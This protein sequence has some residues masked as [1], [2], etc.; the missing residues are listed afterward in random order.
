MSGKPCSQI[1]KLK[2]AQGECVPFKGI[3]GNG[4][5]GRNKQASNSQDPFVSSALSLQEL[6]SLHGSLASEAVSQDG[7]ALTMRQLY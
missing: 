2:V 3:S 6:G 5:P 7:P 1:I 4:A